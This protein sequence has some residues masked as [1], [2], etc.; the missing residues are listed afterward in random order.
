[1]PIRC[2]KVDMK[3]GKPIALENTETKKEPY[4]TL[5][6]RWDS[7]KPTKRIEACQ[8]IKGNFEDRLNGKG[9]DDLPEHFRDAFKIAARLG[10]QY[11]WIDSLCIIQAGDDGNDFNIQ[12]S[13]MAQYYQHSLLTIAT[14][15]NDY[16]TEGI[17]KDPKT[18]PWSNPPV[19]LQYRGANSLAEAAGYFYVYKRKQRL[20]DDYWE[21]VRSVEVFNR[22]W[23]LQEWMLS[24]R[25]LWYTPEG[26]F[27][28]CHSIAPR[29]P[30]GEQ[31]S[32]DISKQELHYLFNLKQRLHWTNTSI[33]DFW[34]DAI[35]V[36]STF[37]IGRISDRVPAVAGL[38]FEV[39][40]IIAAVA[41]G[42]RQLDE[43]AVRRVVYIA[44]LWLQDIHRGLLWEV[45]PSAPDAT[46]SVESVPS[47]SWISYFAPVKFP[48]P[49]SDVCHEMVVTGLCLHERTGR[50]EPQWECAYNKVTEMPPEGLFD[51]GNKFSC[52]HIE[53]VVLRV[54]IRGYL[55]RLKDIETVAFATCYGETPKAGRWR[56]IHANF[57]DDIIIGWASVE[58]LPRERDVCDDYGSEVLA[59]H[60]STRYFTVGW[61]LTRSLPVLDLLFI[62][63]KAGRA[64]V[65]E[66]IGVGRVF[67]NSTVQRFR[68]AAKTN[69]QLI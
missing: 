68:A 69:A 34:Y 22:A 60:V 7:D 9:L 59:L 30:A 62:K 55:Q 40:N 13:K 47:W 6:H 44:G 36:N 66:R 51:L 3:N 29:T 43:T 42:E 16:L 21:N 1:M 39:A 45:D 31:I 4:I 20:I 52:L 61:M 64:G 18:V 49:D 56:A 32:L 38:G 63:E 53:G 41:P 33:M 12:K 24:K 19:R 48:K 67:E 25:F 37:D 14:T 5:T 11:V 28:E 50:H 2:I 15:A 10:V 57:D 26:M 35:E 23:I 58:R 46:R 17:L 54:W 65:Y 8:T 27:F